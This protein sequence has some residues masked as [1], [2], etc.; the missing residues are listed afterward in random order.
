LKNVGLTTHRKH[1]R[2]TKIESEASIFKRSI[3]IEQQFSYREYY[4]YTE[5]RHAKLKKLWAFFKDNQTQL[6]T[7]RMKEDEQLEKVM[8][9]E[10][11]ERI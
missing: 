4:V 11:G 1:G 8:Q 5:A 9:D 6:E 2:F 7:L 10:K 3:D